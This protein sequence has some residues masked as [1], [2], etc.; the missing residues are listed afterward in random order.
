MQITPVE[1]VSYFLKRRSIY[2][3]SHPGEDDP[4]KER[5]KLALDWVKRQLTPSSELTVAS[6]VV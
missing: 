5:R 4:R 1:R 3:V 6:T 2:I